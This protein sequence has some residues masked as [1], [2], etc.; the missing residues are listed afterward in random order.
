METGMNKKHFI[1]FILIFLVQY[2]LWCKVNTPLESTN[3]L[4][5]SEAEKTYIDHLP[6]LRYS[7]DPDWMPYESFTSDGSHIGVAADVLKI[8]TQRTGIKLAK[9]RPS[10]WVQT[11]NWMRD[12]DIDVFSDTDDSVLKE[13]M[14]FTKPYLSDN[15]III[16]HNE[17]ELHLKMEDI[18]DKRVALV[19]DYGYANAF[20]KKN[21][22]T[23]IVLLNTIT[24]A[25]E[26]V[27]SHEADYMITSGY[28]AAWMLYLKF[29]DLHIAGDTGLVT[30]LAFA[31]N[32]KYKAMVPIFN[33]AIDSLTDEDRANIKNRWMP[34]QIVKNDYTNVMYMLIFVLVLVLVGYGIYRNLKRELEIRKTLQLELTREKNNFETL[35]KSSADGNAIILDKKFVVCN[36]AFLQLFKMQSEEEVI[37]KTPESLS[38]EYQPDGERSEVKVE[39]NFTTM[40]AKGKMRFE[41]LHKTVDNEPIWCDIVL[42]KIA[43]NSK[44]GMFVQIRSI[45][46]IKIL[47]ASLVSLK[48]KAEQA[49]QAKS[50]FLANMS[51]EIRTPMNAVMGFTELLEK[52]EGLNAAQ[53]NYVKSIKNGAKNLLSIINDILDLSKIE[54]G[55]LIIKAEPF[56]V[57]VLVEDIKSVF[58]PLISEKKIK[59]EVNVSSD[60]PHVLVADDVRLRQI[61]FNLMSNAIKFTEEGTIFFS[62]TMNSLEREKQVADLSFCVRDTGIGIAPH[63]QLNIFKEFEQSDQQSTRKYGGTGLGLAISRKL[64][65]GMGAAITLNSEK[66]K[67]SEFIVHF[68][69]IGY[70]ET[71]IHVDTVNYSAV[72][73]FQKATIL[74][75]DDIEENLV[76]MRAMLGEYPFEVVEACNGQEALDKLSSG[77]FDLV[78]A[79]IRMPVMDGY[80]LLQ[81]MQKNIVFNSIP[82]IA[83]T[84]SLLNDEYD[85]LMGR[86]F[87][88]VLGKPYKK[89]ELDHV[90]S[91][92]IPNTYAEETHV[93]TINQEGVHLQGE[94]QKGYREKFG[95]R[96]QNQLKRNNFSELS[97]LV[98]DMR[99]FLREN[100]HK[101]FESVVLSLE[102]A[103]NEFDVVGVNS[104]FK[105]LIDNL[106]G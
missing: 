44:I 100:P 13:Q 29:Q 90:L 76:L 12:G 21:P 23:P 102:N 98:V 9:V 26:A 92:F 45:D 74:S 71:D 22:N 87:K 61:L 70:E 10:S 2:P 97:A 66:G 86:G 91:Q 18:K 81:E 88:G 27:Q 11:V 99:E 94:I 65:D 67:G 37:G 77:H 106:E 38:P 43:Y 5:L 83:V 19:R 101:E 34:S 72:Y 50:Q 104:I 51:H 46:D 79:D 32:P 8:L 73:R 36:K 96:I 35:F 89:E 30:H 80:Q 41:W 15:V 39:Q 31:F 105:I 75:V 63:D 40:L 42:T 54:A 58:G 68:P 57:T 47:E 33:K 6:V 84:A 24:E 56:D 53:K 14:A 60:I 95:D 59:F 62:V 28:E 93:E 78:L 20:M 103:I 52:S 85:Q 55:K 4:K 82:V 16:S 17:R 49:N 3:T 69:S 48:V 64:A 25:M 1:T 7:S